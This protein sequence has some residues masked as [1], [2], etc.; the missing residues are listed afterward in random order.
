[1]W[2]G[3][4]ARTEFKAKTAPPRKKKQEETELPKP[5]KLKFTQT[6]ADSA[7]ADR[8]IAKAVDGKAETGWQPEGAPLTDPHSAL[9][10]LAEPMQVQPD[11]ELRIRLRYEASKSRRAIGRFRLAV[12]QNDELVQHLNPPKLD[13]WQVIGPFKSPDQRTGFATVHEPE[14]E[15]D[16]KKSYPGVRE[17]VKWNAKSDFEDGKANLLVQDLHGLP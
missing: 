15:I 9:F 13:A 4:C 10:L 3:R 6:V 5:K 17:D 11:S 16:L 1:A 14:K 12:A 7:A 8:D 2:D